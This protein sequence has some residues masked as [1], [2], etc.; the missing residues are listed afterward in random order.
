MTL[1]L[2]TD[3]SKFQRNIVRNTLQK[4]GYETVE[5]VNG[6]EALIAIEEHQPDAMSLDLLMPEL[7]GFGVLEA[8]KNKNMKIPVVVCSADIQ[9]TTKKRCIELGA[10]GFINKPLKPDSLERLISILKSKSI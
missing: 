4:A 8:M 3:D 10:T 1:I 6:K 7:D 2:I 9:E 5:A